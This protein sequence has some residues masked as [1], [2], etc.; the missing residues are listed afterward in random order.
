MAAMMIKVSELCSYS[1]LAV[2]P[3]VYLFIFSLCSANL[4]SMLLHSYYNNFLLLRVIEYWMLCN[5][6]VCFITFLRCVYA[7]LYILQYT[8][9]VQ[10]PRPFSWVQ[11]GLGMRLLLPIIHSKHTIIIIMLKLCSI[12][13]PISNYVFVHAMAYT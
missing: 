7:C 6:C 10:F 12:F 8:R 2:R 4:T 1:L 3:F 11:K 9:C 5:T 13:S